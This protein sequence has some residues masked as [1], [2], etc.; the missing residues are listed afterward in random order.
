MLAPTSAY[1]LYRGHRV[2]A[3]GSSIRSQRS[4]RS[5]P[6]HAVGRDRHSRD[7]SGVEAMS[8]ARRPRPGVPC[9]L[10]RPAPPPCAP[11]MA[12]LGLLVASQGPCTLGTHLETA[13]RDLTAALGGEVVLLA[14]SRAPRGPAGR[15]SV[16]FHDVLP[17]GRGAPPAA[18][19]GR[20]RPRSRVARV[21]RSRIRSGGHDFAGR[22][23][24]PGRRWTSR[25]CV[26]WSSRMA[27][28]P[29]ARLPAR[30]PLRRAGPTRS[31]VPAGCGATVGIGGQALGGGLGP[32]GRSRGLRRTK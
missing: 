16:R 19:R 15:R 24:A 30:R 25:R 23:L 12:S 26:P 18:R 4:R 1:R 32:L 28:P 22:C 9:W 7:D 3:I 13:L 21:S 8:A 29:G 31:H 20:G 5:R 2:S 14:R 11:P 17:A 10:A 6:G 27:W